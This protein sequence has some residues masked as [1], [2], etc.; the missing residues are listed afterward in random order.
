MKRRRTFTLFR[1]P[2]FYLLNGIYL[3][4]VFVVIIFPLAHVVSMSLSSPNAVARGWVWIVP[5]EFSLKAYVAIAQNQTILLGLYNSLIYAFFGTLVNITVTIMAAY[6]LSKKIYGKGVITGFFI[7][8]MFFSGG[9]IPTYLVVRSLGMVNTRWAMI[10][11]GALSVWLMVITRVYF[12]TQIPSELCDSA[13]VDG[14][15][16]LTYLFRIVIPLSKPII[17]VLVLLYAVGHWNSYFNA[18]IY[19][20]D[21]RLHNLQL[22]LRNIIVS[23]DQLRFMA[24]SAGNLF[25]AYEAAKY[26]EVLKYAVIVFASLPVMILYPFIQRHFVKAIM[27]GSLKG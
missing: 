15:S 19:L 11:P 4:A 1:N 23:A 18:L 17:A 2:L 3:S 26:I 24:D 27:L 12:Q 10:I 6:P 8:T 25:Q 16:H 9:L 13:E 20:Y 14:A 5:V 22:V 21:N 7:L